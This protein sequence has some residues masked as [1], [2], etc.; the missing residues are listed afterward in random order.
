LTQK[1][2][3]EVEKLESVARHVS[4]PS[5]Q[6]GSIVKTVGQDGEEKVSVMVSSLE[7]LMTFATYIQ[8]TVCMDRTDVF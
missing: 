1:Y 2:G 6:S 4:S 5:I 8:S 3:I 7:V